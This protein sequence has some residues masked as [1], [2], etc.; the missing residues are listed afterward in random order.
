MRHLGTN[1]AL[2]H[3]MSEMPQGEVSVAF[4]SDSTVCIPYINYGIV[5]LYFSSYA[6]LL[7]GFIVHTRIALYI[8]FHIHMLT[9]KH[10]VCELPYPIAKYHEAALLGEH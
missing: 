2:L 5:L 9:V 3:K 6:M 4:H 10:G 8:V 7:L 1:Y